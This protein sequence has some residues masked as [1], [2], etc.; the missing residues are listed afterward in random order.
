MRGRER[1]KR[2]KRE[3]ERGEG[4]GGEECDRRSEGGERTRERDRRGGED[5]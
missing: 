1:R 5:K 4:Q 3:T 2:D